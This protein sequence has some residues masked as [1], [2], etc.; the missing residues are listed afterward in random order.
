MKISNGVKLSQ[1]KSK[2]CEGVVSLLPEKEALQ[3]FEKLNQWT[4]KDNK[5]QKV[6][7]FSDFKEAMQFVNVVADIAENAGHHPDIYI[8][9]NK[10][11]IILWTH[12]IEGLSLND[13]ILAAKI[14]DTQK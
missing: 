5:I 2:P 10:V 3:L 4:I 8:F 13:F 6:F 12:A 7:K 14:D 1:Q 11:E 9:Y